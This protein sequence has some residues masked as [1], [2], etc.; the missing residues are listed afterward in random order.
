MNASVEEIAGKYIATL[1]GELDTA[2]ASEVEEILKPLY[3]A[4]NPDIVIDCSRL[5]YIA[6]SGL[7]ILLSI[8]KSAKA[9][10]GKVVLRNV[11]EDIKSVFKMTGFVNIFDFE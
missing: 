11:N 2:A 8:L 5:Q 1:D 3:S 4:P 7:R 10:G 9:N 6:S